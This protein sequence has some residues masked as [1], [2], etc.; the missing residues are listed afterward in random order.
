MIVLGNARGKLA[1]DGRY[2]VLPNYGLA[3]HRTINT[4][5][6]TLLQAAGIDRH[7]FGSPDPN[8]DEAMYRGP[9]AELVHKA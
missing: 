1:T 2:V 4:V 8:L 6:N 5:Y 9:L 3:G 7:D